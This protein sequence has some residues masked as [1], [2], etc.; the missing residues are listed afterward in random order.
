MAS[1]EF[2]TFRVVYCMN[3][4]HALLLTTHVPGTHQLNLKPRPLAARRPEGLTWSLDPAVGVGR[5]A[6][7]ALAPIGPNRCC[8]RVR[9]RRSRL[10]SPQTNRCRYYHHWY[11][12]LYR[13]H[14][15]Q[16]S[17][18]VLVD[19]AVSCY[20]HRRPLLFSYFTHARYA[21]WSEIER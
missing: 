20:D 13:C 12:S 17:K 15:L 1:G 19:K 3:L 4:P 6:T 11:C 2:L 7:V 21:L 18:L 16:L 9:Q 14:C 8:L 5:S 10:T